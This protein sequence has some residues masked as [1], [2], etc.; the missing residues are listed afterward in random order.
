MNKVF[1]IR[2]KVKKALGTDGYPDTKISDVDGNDMVEVSFDLGRNVPLDAIT[3][4]AKIEELKDHH[5]VIDCENGTT[6]LRVPFGA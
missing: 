4:I 2:Q 3:E 5:S 6:I 1:L